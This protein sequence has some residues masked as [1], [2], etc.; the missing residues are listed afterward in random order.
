MPQA[1]RT[2][3]VLSQVTTLSDGLSWRI[4]T[5]NRA[6]RFVPL[7]VLKRASFDPRANSVIDTGANTFSNLLAYMIENDVFSML[8]AVDKT[9]YIH[10]IVGGGDTLADTANGFY[11]IAQKVSGV[12]IVLWS[13]EHFGPL[14]TAEGKSFVETRAYTQSVSRLAGMVLLFKRNAATFGEDIRKLNTKRHTIAEALASADYT[15]M[16]RQQLKMFGRD[17]FAQ[18]QAMQW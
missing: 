7:P 8:R 6:M 2:Y 3:T 12:P 17:V 5:Y 1:S 11:A 10:T 16:E 4:T 9:P 18:L 14:R 15:I 13:N